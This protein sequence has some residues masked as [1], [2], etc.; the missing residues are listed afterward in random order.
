[1]KPGAPPPPAH[2]GESDYQRAK[3]LAGNHHRAEDGESSWLVSYADMMTL[4]VGFFLILL[5]FSKIDSK[6]FERVKKEATKTFGGEYKM[7]FEKLTNEIKAA[8]EAQKISDQVLFKQTDAGIEI[9]FRGALFFDRGGAELRPEATTL[10]DRIIPLLIKQAA[11]FGILIEGHTDNIPI[12]SHMFASNW[13]LSSVRA[14]SVLRLFEQRG[15]N[16]K[17]LKAVGYADK[18]PVLPNEDAQGNPLPDNQSQN[19]RVVVKVL[20]N[21]DLDQ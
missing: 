9:A 2:P 14:C 1:M 15:Y 10:L 17:R 3:R 12:K 8:I 18:R 7:P 21:F 11:T 13:E 5:S 4:L 16:P 20:K 19:R 6:A